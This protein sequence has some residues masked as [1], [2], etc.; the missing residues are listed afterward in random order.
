MEFF[1][2]FLT[3]ESSK[4]FQ[5]FQDVSNKEKVLIPSIFTAVYPLLFTGLIFCWINFCKNEK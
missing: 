1:K 5:V 4:N 2:D 3:C